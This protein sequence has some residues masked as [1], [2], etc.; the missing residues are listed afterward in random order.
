MLIGADAFGGGAPL[1][2]D[3]SVD[4]ERRNAERFPVLEADRIDENERRELV[5]IHKRVSRGKHAAGRVA[6]EDNGFDS[7]RRDEPCVF[8]ASA[9][10]LY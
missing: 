2:L 3:P 4:A 5:R 9:W 6:D 8:S 7:E 10:K 1:P